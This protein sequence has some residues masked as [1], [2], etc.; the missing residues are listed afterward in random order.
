MITNGTA[1][2]TT[3]WV[4]VL[5]A[6]L[7]TAL[8]GSAVASKIEKAIPSKT[9][10]TNAPSTAPTAATGG[11]RVVSHRS[12]VPSEGGE[13]EDVPEEADGVIKFV[14]L[15]D[16][17]NSFADGTT[18]TDRQ[19][20]NPVTREGYQQVRQKERFQIDIESKLTER[21]RDEQTGHKQHRA[22]HAQQ[23]GHHGRCRRLVW[24]EFHIRC[25]AAI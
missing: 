20:G 1:P 4:T 7:S 12:E 10:W 21:F 15:E 3:P 5:P 8:S 22:G 23:G 19:R 13:S 2:R 24:F 25:T 18:E 16:I 11:S 6:T 14:V 17:E 9:A